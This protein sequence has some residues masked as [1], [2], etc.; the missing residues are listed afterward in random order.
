MTFTATDDAGNTTTCSFT[1]TVVD[2]DDPTLECPSDINQN[3]DA[4]EC[5]AVITFTTPEAFDN[6]GNVTVE[7]TG[8]PASGEQFP[9]GTTTVTFTATDDA[10]NSVDCSFNVTVNDNEAPEVDEM[11]DIVVSND[12]GECGAIVTYDVV[13]TTDNCE[14]STI[15]VT[16]GPASGTE[17]EVGTTT[18]TYTVTDINGN[19][20]TE[21]FTVTVN[22][23]EAPGLTCPQ[24][25]TVSTTTGE[26]FAIVTFMEAT[27]TDN[28][29]ATVEQ[30]AGPVSGSPF[31]LGTTTV[32]FTAT[33]DAGNT[34]EC[35]FTVTVEDDSDPTLECPSDISQNVD[36]GECGAVVTFSTPEAFDNSGNVTVEQTAG[37]NS[38]E[39]FPVGIT[40][41]TFTATDD[42][43][44]SAECSFT[45]TV[46]D[47]EVPV[48][49]DMVDINVNNDPGACG[50]I[51]NFESPGATDNCGIESL[52]QTEG[53]APGTEF[54]VGTTTVV[55]TATD[56]NG[57][58]A[59][60][61]FT[62]T[63]TDNESPSVECPDNITLTAEFGT[64]F[65]TVTYN[66]LTVTDNCEGTTVVLT[67]GF[68]SGEQFPVG[69]TTTVMYSITDAAGNNVECIFTVT[70]TED[71][72]EPP[73]PPSASV[74]TAATCDDPFGTITV[75]TQEGLTYSIDGE[76]Y[77]ESGVFEDLPP[78]VYDVTAKDE[79]DQVSI[80]TTITIEDPIAEQIDTV[81]GQ[82]VCNDSG[83]FNLSSLL[84]GNFD[85]T[86][87]WVDT[88]NSGG[89]ENGVI[90]PSII[91]PGFYD[92]EYVIEGICAST[93]RVTV[94]IT[95][96]I[97]LDCS[98]TDLRESISKA[99]TPNG[100]NFND[101][102][103]VGLDA[104]CGFTY[105]LKIFNRWG[106]EVY[107]ARN[108][109]NN[110]DG[111]S[112]KSFTSSNQL[113]SGTYYY[114]LEIRNSEFEPIQ[115]YIYLGTK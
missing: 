15:T 81:I 61:T 36:A 28:C 66:E 75:E 22:D 59:T 78:G 46:G 32:T 84:R 44:N 76:N 111:F 37:P 18:V 79:F 52:T 26:S 2:E 70:I 13:T 102:F 24:D 39:Q 77:Q 86:G 12:P 112:E 109:Q 47:D 105:D 3:V 14:I 106:A 67:E 42:A 21:S 30:T 4:G 54:P 90:D 83:L 5:G 7:Q 51:V 92:F 87:T 53:M 100:D 60:S 94:E 114:I 101:F 56:T 19:S 17:F 1:V 73:S 104:G 71:N 65:L 91:T 40:T 62:V 58:T 45:V 103:T 16:E 82:E 108:Y 88:E 55:Y 113:P 35:S 8:G 57:N 93:T 11:Q 107:T 80:A 38:G 23:T 29:G 33:D 10:G 43:G 74:T 50:A 98:I 9:V 27:V 20:T 6:S 25:I 72:P 69:E 89:L 97:V 95:D 85:D 115:G 110:W 96:C 41:V 48:I 99:V 31:S 68:A 63:V 49:E 64:E 34:T